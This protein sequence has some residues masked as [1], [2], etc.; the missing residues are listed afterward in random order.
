[1][2]TTWGN[3]KA[4]LRD[5][6]LAYCFGCHL[7]AQPEAAAAFKARCARRRV[8]PRCGGTIILNYVPPEL[9]GTRS[10]VYD[11]K[12]AEMYD[13]P[14]RPEKDLAPPVGR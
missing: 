4:R 9:V 2:A 8:C 13:P 1:M 12:D 5:D 11:Y 10:S 7:V 6:L 14:E 3:T